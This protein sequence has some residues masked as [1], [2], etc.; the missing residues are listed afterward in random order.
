VGRDV[1]FVN[2]CT[3]QC[4]GLKQYFPCTKKLS[5]NQ[6]PVGL[7]EYVI[8]GIIKLGSREPAAN[9]SR[10]APGPHGAEKKIR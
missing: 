3:H 7:V 9:G 1:V 6:P 8:H 10:L 4:R 5:E 2:E